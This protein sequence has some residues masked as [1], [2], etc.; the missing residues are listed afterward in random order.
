VVKKPQGHSRAHIEPASSR[1]DSLVRCRSG[2]LPLGWAGWTAGHR[3][4]GAAPELVGYLSHEVIETVIDPSGAREL[5]G[6][7]AEA[8]DPVARAG[9]AWTE[10]GSPIS[11]TPVG[12]WPARLVRSI[13]ARHAPG[14]GRVATGWLSGFAGHQGNVSRV[15][16]ATV[17]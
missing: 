7:L 15:M 6:K 2:R 5:F 1:F 12:S 3:G 4:G 8:C 11:S 14:R 13:T 17:A 16:R 10:Y 9:T